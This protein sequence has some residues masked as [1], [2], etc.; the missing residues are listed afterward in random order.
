IRLLRH[1]DHPGVVDLLDEGIERDG[2]PWYVMRLLKG[3]PLLTHMRRIA[4]A[5]AHAPTP[6]LG[7]R[8]S[9]LG[10]ASTLLLDAARAADQDPPPPEPAN[11][12]IEPDDRFDWDPDLSREPL[13]WMRQLCETLA[14][15]HGE[16]I[17]H[18]DL[19]PE[20]IVVT[21]DGRAILVDFGIAERFGARVSHEVLEAAGVQAGTPHYISPEQIR[22]E[23]VDARTDLYALGCIF[24]EILTGAPP[25]DGGSATNILMHHLTSPAPRPST[26]VSALPTGFDALCERL[27]AKAPSER[28]G[29]ARV[30]AGALES[31]GV[32]TVSWPDAPTPRPYLYKPGLAGREALTRHLHELVLSV[33]AGAPHALAISG[34][35][36]AG[37]SRVAAELIAR[38]RSQQMLA[39]SSQCQLM[40]AGTDESLVGDPL[41]AFAPMLRNVADACL[42][43]GP[44]WTARLLGSRAR[45]LSPYA[46][47]L[48][49]LPTID[50][51]APPPAR[52]PE[53]ARRRLFFALAQTLEQ[54]T[55]RRPTLFLFDDLHFADELSLEA[56]EH[57]LD[58]AQ[59]EELP[60][61]IT[62]MHR[63]EDIPE[64]L[65]P[66]L[67][68]ARWE[69]CPLERLGDKALGE[70]TAQMLGLK[71]TPPPLLSLIIQRTGGNPFYVAEYLRLALEEGLLQQDRQGAWQLA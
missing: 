34:E 29:H 2:T 32:A 60:W 17:V 31:L 56:I 21:E 46:P 33:K 13:V 8:A 26:R 1:L 63:S 10:F 69:R 44:Q 40:D 22:G 37:K 15:V 45:I 61:L 25:F 47:F 20:N 39:M 3:S 9:S 62:I 30:V 59:E 14:Y 57:L 11:T 42:Q 52:D 67:S 4:A 24:F 7:H 16:G 41:H 65:E 49:E 55:V 5:H 6:R 53:A 28:I 38:A 43:E 18:C 70:L 68:D 54:A 12:P 35:S 71:E 50:R 48:K 36:G 27:L 58:F 51:S 19:K 23:P 64:R 66:L